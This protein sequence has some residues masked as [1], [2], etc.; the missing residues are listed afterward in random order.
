MRKFFWVKGVKVYAFNRIDST[1]NEAVRRIKSGLNLP[2]LFVAKSQTAGKGTRGRSFYSGGGGLYMSLALKTDEIRL[3]KLTVLAAVATAK[4]I[5]ALSGKTVGIKWVNDIYIGNKKLCGIL[6]E[7]V[8]NPT[9][10]KTLGVVIGI[11]V[12]LFVKDFPPELHAIA[13]SLNKNGVTPKKLAIEITNQILSLT[14]GGQDFMQYYKEKSILLG[15]EITYIKNNNEYIAT[16]VDID[17]SG[18]LIVKDSDQNTI[19]LSSGDVM[20]KK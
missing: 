1:N 5:E 3:Q 11:G 13:V 4:A 9:N 20:L 19:V 6:C 7:R 12:N 8:A 16:A 14:A 2:A 18:A 17:D 15:K 10:G